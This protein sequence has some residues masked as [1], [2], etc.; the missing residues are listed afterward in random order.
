MGDP[1]R[2]SGS[3]QRAQVLFV[4]GCAGV[5][6]S[7]V[8]AEIHA[9]LSRARVRHALIEGDVLDLAWPAPHEQGLRLAELNLRAIWRGYEQAG[10]RRLVYINTASVTADAMAEL[11]NALGGTASVDGVLLT[12]RRPAVV[13]RLKQREKGTEPTVVAP[14]SRSARCG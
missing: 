11:T 10:Y 13:M 14:P 4:G 3:S 5:G 8:G 1:G 12:A 7:S 2:A 9:Q 6:K